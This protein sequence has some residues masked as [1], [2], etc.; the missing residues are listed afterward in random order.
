VRA[1][2]PGGVDVA[3]D[4]V[5]TDEAIDVSLALVNDRQRILTCAA[6]QRAQTDGIRYIGGMLPASAQYR[7]AVRPRLIALAAEG[8]LVIPVARTFPLSDVV[9]ALT[10]L[11]TGH[12]GGKLALIP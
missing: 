7:A 9:E 5:G 10:L 8:K 11:K 6:F 3:I 4:T 2:A 1:L 12:P